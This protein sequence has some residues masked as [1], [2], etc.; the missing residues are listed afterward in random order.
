VYCAQPYDAGIELRMLRCPEAKDWRCLDCEYRHRRRDLVFS[1]VQ[2]NHVT[3]FPG[4]SCAIC[5]K[6]SRTLLALNKHRTR[7][8]RDQSLQHNMPT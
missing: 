7:A 6:F 2:A 5:G 4:Y 3:D 8:H 1:H